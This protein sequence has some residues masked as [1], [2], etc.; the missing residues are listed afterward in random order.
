VAAPSDPQTSPARAWTACA[1]LVL[2]AIVMV[3]GLL[4]LD[5]E[6]GGALAWVVAPAV[7]LT[8]AA[9]ALV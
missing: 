3:A 7:V 9:A 8:A 1:L 5:S 6:P 4:V 2:A